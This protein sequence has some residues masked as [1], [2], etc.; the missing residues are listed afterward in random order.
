MSFTMRRLRGQQLQFPVFCH[1]SKDT[2]FLSVYPLGSCCVPPRK[3]AEAGLFPQLIPNAI[4]IS[5]EKTPEEGGDGSVLSKHPG[6]PER[7]EEAQLTVL[8]NSSN[9]DSC[10]SLICRQLSSVSVGGGRGGGWL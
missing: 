10:A 4:V 7:V 5:L 3:Q 9:C 2:L 1:Y 8:K 6:K